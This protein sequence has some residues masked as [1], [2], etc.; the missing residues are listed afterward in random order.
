MARLMEQLINE[1]KNDK[2]KNI[3]DLAMK[4]MPLEYFDYYS[5]L[6]SF[7]EGYYAV[8]ENVKARALLT[9]LM[10]KYKDNLNYYKDLSTSEQSD[11]AVE[12]VT[13]LERYRSLL[14]IMK[15]HEDI[16]FYNDN[17]KTFNS[18]NQM[19]RHFGR[20]NETGIERVETVIDSI[21]IDS[22]Q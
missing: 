17:K 2:A 10:N 19:F 1:G 12:I 8:D 3:I 9:Q 6:N 13:N 22:L 11:L 4:K 18:Y 16:S 14:H 7:A 15:A 21:G 5:L 20:E